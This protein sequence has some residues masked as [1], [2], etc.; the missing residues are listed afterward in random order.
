MGKTIIYIHGSGPKPDAQSLSR[1]WNKAVAHGLE[2][3]HR[4]KLEVFN[5]AQYEFVYYGDLNNE[6]SARLQKEYDPELDMADRNNV[7]DA[8]MAMKP[9]SFASRRR[10][11]RSSEAPLLTV[12]PP[13]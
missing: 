11:A 4:D 10:S 2:R 12:P 5:E 6:N 8:L 3:H 13:T 7:L 1:Y 9:K